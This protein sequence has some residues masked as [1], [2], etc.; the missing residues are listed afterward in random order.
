MPRRILLGLLILS[1][2]SAM[3]HGQIYP[4][5]GR[6]VAVDSVPM[7]PQTA[8]LPSIEPT[9]VP[10]VVEVGEWIEVETPPVDP[11]LFGEV[12]V[13]EGGVELGL[14]GAEGNTKTFNMRF[15]VD[16]KLETPHNILTLDLDYHK[17]DS[18]Y[19]E[20]A[21]RAF[22]DSRFERLYDDSRWTSFVH[23]TLDYDEFQSFDS[24]W[25]ADL[26]L[27]YRCIKRELTSLAARFGA[28]VSQEVGGPDESYVPEAVFGLDF[29][30]KL[31]DRQKLT[32]SIEYT[33]EMTGFHD[34]R[35][36]TRG[37]WEV[38]IDQEMNLSLKF[39]IT[40]RYDSTPNGAIPNDLDYSAVLLWKF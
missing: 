21:N 6:P 26:G 20:T 15:G 3:A 10:G 9:V 12:G 28:G 34:Y 14:N 38:L 23:S 33:P 11:G 13:W 8:Q 19:V 16:A 30:H 5:A 35:L 27:G 37:S 36:R 32:A 29:S 40:D 2:T 31:T 24:R 18:N 25:A 17:T 39:N 4:V 22:L 1:L 7:N